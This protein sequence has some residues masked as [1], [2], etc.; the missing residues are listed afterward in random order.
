MRS[1]RLMTAVV[2]V[3]AAMGVGASAAMAESHPFVG[4]FGSFSNPNGIAVD[5]SSGDVYVADIGTNTVS[6]F[7]ANG[8][9]VDF[10]CG[11]QCSAYVTGNEITGT[12]TGSFAFPDAPGT[13]AAIAVDDSTSPS[14]PSRGDLY[15]MDAG[16]DVIDKFNAGG[17]YLG[18]LT[19]PTP[20]KFVSVAGL[21]V[22]A[23]GYV[24]VDERNPEASPDAREAVVEFDDSPSNYF[25]KLVGFDQNAE[26]KLIS[27]TPLGFAAGP[28]GDRYFLTSLCGCVEKF[29][30]RGEYLGRVDGKS[31]TGVAVAVDQAT[32]HV[33]T[34]EQSSVL[35]WDT[36]QMNGYPKESPEESSRPGLGAQVASFGSL[37]LVA[38]TGEGGIAVNAD[39]GQVYV[40]DP[41]AH[42]VEVFGTA[43]PGVT[44][45]PAAAVTQTG[46]TLQGSVNPRGATVT[47]CR[48]EYGVHG[49]Y[50]HSVPCGL[51]AAQIDA[52]VSPVAVSAVVAGLEPGLLYDFRLVAENASGASFTSARFATAGPGFGVKSLELAFTNQDGSPDTQAGSHPYQMTTAFTLNTAFLNTAALPRETGIDAR[53]RLEPD[54]NIR[55]VI[56]TLPPGLVGDPNATTEKCTAADLESDNRPGCPP[57]SEVGY[58]EVELG[59]QRGTNLHLSVTLYNI[60]SPHG[61]AA[62]F[63][64]NFI[65]PSAFINNVLKPGGDYGYTATSEAAPTTAPVIA[66]KVV[67]FG[68]GAGPCVVGVTEGKQENCPP[69]AYGSKKLLLTL[70]GSCNGPLKASISVDSY[71]EPGHF[72]EASTVTHRA[73]G[74]PGGLTGCS[75][76]V[77]PPT[78]EVTP[79]VP[80]ASTSTGLNV[81]V[82]VSQKAGQNP[83]G[84]A[85]STL[86]D[87]TVALPAGVAI[88]PAGA[89]GL[90]AC[91]EGLAGF[92]GFQ[93]FNPE[94][95]PGD[96]TP[97]FTPSSPGSL[98]PGV[99]FCPNGSKI[100]TVKIKTPL[101]PNPLEGFVYLAA[102]DANPFGS[103]VAMYMVVE[104][105]VSG[106]VIK[107]AGEVRLCES[108]GEVIEGVSC[109]GLG[110]IVT[111]FKDT[112]QQ[113]FEDLELHFFGGER[114][115]LSTP[116]RCGTYT[117]QA[118][119]VPWD[120]NGPVNT[121]SSFKI[122]SGPNGGPC[123]GA[124]LPF[125]PTVNA[126]ATNIQAGA[127]SPLTVTLNR[128]DGEQ[129][130]KSV[131]AKLPPGLSGV[132]SGVELCPEPR[133]NQGECGENSKVGE[134]TVSV[135]VGNQPFT[136]TGGKFYLTG[137]YN[138]SGGC[139]V[140]EA[141]CAPFGLTF[142]VP[143]K[144]GPFDL[145]NTANRHPACD[146]VVVRGKIE[147]NPLTSAITITTD[148]AGA[149]G[150]GGESSDSIPTSIDGIPLEIQHVNAT[151]TRGDFQFNPTNCA[152]LAL[153]ATVQ[154]SEGG[155]STISTPFQV[156]NCA[157]LKF[158]PKFSVSTSGKTSKAERREPDGEAHLPE[159]AL[160]GTQANIA[161]VKVDLP[162]QLPSRLTTL[163]KG[164]H[165][166]T[167]QH[168]PGGVPGGVE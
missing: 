54:G 157:A 111:T 163:Q 151:T 40:A 98:Q 7:D 147:L 95:E 12:P 53:Y 108:A 153:E 13:P 8:N 128:K 42:A 97:T 121:T 9:P 137:P 134:A 19:G 23:N 115:P 67:L 47:A 74:S 60:V 150:S 145:E 102:Q 84:L 2:L 113:P 26:K 58:I 155:S 29:S 16:H 38:G 106:T 133:A 142:E 44:V 112:P 104:D 63:G 130:L 103:L 22:D 156:T 141:G 136:V 124:S 18:Q 86:R 10:T 81:D 143:A 35:E 110:Q 99:S 139:T 161:Q 37:Q 31:S 90:E 77:F 92:S 131:E 52:G 73:D 164:V 41:A 61:V 118:S 165:R 85:E 62:Q 109:R 138:G 82:H 11:A 159:R 71:Q 69:S 25:L 120:G 20:K 66:T 129:N 158:E 166:R 160:Q 127:F 167:V 96:R 123:P 154:L 3:V 27:G 119:F 48:F 79:D 55:D 83:E 45:G 65:I 148:Q 100:G 135:G 116:S 34:D 152:K 50:S 36:G 132:L 80:D 21:A 1:R 6:K 107:L 87:T 32:G 28:S 33:Y 105:P 149:G 59:E 140:G 43:V 168:Q 51:T 78:I 146:C 4:S 76:L 93:V 30:P 68:G 5:E 39:T 14:D 49:S 57:A 88:N 125:N 24:W 72:V 114:A 162:K 122:T 75:K 91:S 46:A 56:V 117:T 101:L 64:G 15:V 17:E 94:F 70:P 126:G 89:D 144:A